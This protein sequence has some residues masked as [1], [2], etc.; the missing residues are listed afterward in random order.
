M[1]PETITILVLSDPARPQIQRLRELPFVK[2]AVGQHVDDLRGA[3]P[4][5]DIILNWLGNR[6]LLEDV[7]ALAPRVRWVHYMWA[8]LDGVLFPELLESAVPVTNGRGVFSEGLGEFAVAAMLYFAKD[9]GR[10]G[11]SQRA[12]LWDPF[13]VDW[14]SGRTVGI[15]GYGEIGRSVARRATALGMSVVALRRRPELSQGDSHIAGIYGPEHLRDMLAR[16]DYLVA[17]APLT[18]GT[19]GMIGS[20]ELDALPQGAVVIN[21]GRGPVIDEGALVRALERN[22]IR[23]AALDVFDTEP[24]PPGHPFFRLENVLLSPHCADRTPDWLDNAMQLFLDNLER[25]RS[26]RPLRNLIDKMT[27]Y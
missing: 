18:P 6:R 7:W 5:A 12:G 1:T 8:G 25:F 4:G 2:T 17:C 13:E 14:L 10:M 15:V 22:R 26:G 3:A 23:G 16:T 27:G 19:R 11:R 20:G 9:F 24:L 21:V